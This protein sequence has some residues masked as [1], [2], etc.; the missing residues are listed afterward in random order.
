MIIITLPNFSQT[1]VTPKVSTIKP[2]MVS[3]LGLPT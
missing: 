2:Y 1:S 3:T